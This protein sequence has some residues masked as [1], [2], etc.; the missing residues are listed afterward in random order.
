ML[1]QRPHDKYSKRLEKFLTNDENKQGFALFHFNEWKKDKYTTYLQGRRICF[2]GA[3]K[4]SWLMSTDGYKTFSDVEK[5]KSTKEAAEKKKKVL[6]CLHFA[7]RSSCDSMCDHQTLMFSFFLSF[8][9]ILDKVL[10]DTGVGNKRRLM[11]TQS[12][13]Q[14][15]GKYICRCTLHPVDMLPPVHSSESEI[16]TIKA[17]R[18][19]PE[20]SDTFAQ[21]GGSEEIPH[22]VFVGTEHFTYLLYGGSSIK[23]I[24][25]L[26]CEKFLQ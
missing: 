5:P 14:D 20:F 3:D 9:K 2:A 24:N 15:E 1:N 8:H 22:N 10:L 16:T 13:I 26:R 19:H 25:K 4:Y 21:L 12:V 7:A 6:H 17:L 18:Q 11:D 23:D